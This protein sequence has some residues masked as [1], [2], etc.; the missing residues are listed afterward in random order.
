[1]FRC[2]ASYKLS[3]FISDY[4]WTETHSCVLSLMMSLDAPRMCAYMFNLTIE[5]ISFPHPSAQSIAF[6]PNYR[7]CRRALLFSHVAL[8]AAQSLTASSKDHVRWPDMSCDPQPGQHLWAS[9]GIGMSDKWLRWWAPD[10]VASKGHPAWGSSILFP[11]FNLDQHR[12]FANAWWPQPK[13]SPVEP[14]SAIWFRHNLFYYS[15]WVKREFKCNLL[16]EATLPDNRKASNLSA[17]CQ[18]N[19]TACCVHLT[20][21]TD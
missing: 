13:V 21:A 8:Q 9:S 5:F 15:G 1:M 10:G 16:V 3:N 6:I 18:F 11:H 14:T 17:L 2:T 12:L 7:W 4:I 19:Y 20:V